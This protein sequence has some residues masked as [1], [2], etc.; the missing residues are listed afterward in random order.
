MARICLLTPTQPSVNPRI[1]KEAD[2]LAEVGHKVHVF[3]GHTIPW[4]DESD[5]RLLGKRKWTCAYVGGMPGSARHWW[6]RVRHGVIRRFPQIW[7]LSRELAKCALARIVPELRAAAL[8][9]D[10][11]LYIAHYVGALAVAAN[12]AKKKGVPFAFDAEDFE[13]GYYEYNTGPRSIDHLT[14]QVEGECLPQCCYVTAASPGIASASALKYGIPTPTSILNVFPLAER[15]LQ[16]RETDARAPLKLYWFSQTIGADRGL[17]DVIRAL[18][19]LRDSDIKIYIRGRSASGYQEQMLRFAS[20]KGLEDSKVHFLPPAPTEDMI[21]LSAEYDVG[22]ALEQPASP[23]R[24]LCL[25]NKIFSYLL[26]GNAVAATSTKGQTA[27]IERL[28]AAGFVYEPGDVEALAR[29]LRM[30]H[31]DRCELDQARRTAWLLATHQF[32]WDIEKRKF[33]QLV[34][35][36]LMQHENSLAVRSSAVG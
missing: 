4:A 6:T 24:D 8:E 20:E 31:D 28:G 14:E 23:N 25:T 30:W 34:N 29:G 2:A 18:A 17:E 36:A 7:K 35:A 1:V 10:A 16:F 12:V 27:I 9:F 22:L 5:E 21:R 33:V 13:S 15:P 19:I 3:C 26:A 32:N 11:D